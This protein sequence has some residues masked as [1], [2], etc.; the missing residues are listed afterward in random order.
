L[1]ATTWTARRD[2]YSEERGEL[3]QIEGVAARRRD[4]VE[5]YQIGG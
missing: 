3:L 2:R 4:R 1:I 5:M